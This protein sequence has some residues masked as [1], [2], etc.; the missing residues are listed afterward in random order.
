LFHDI[1]IHKNYSLLHQRIQEN[2]AYLVE[3]TTAMEMQRKQ[4]FDRFFQ[5]IN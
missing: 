3:Q 4:T 1:L 2:K 5:K